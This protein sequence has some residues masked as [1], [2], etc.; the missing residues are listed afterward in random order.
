[1]TPLG[2][3]PAYYQ[4]PA[5]SPDGTRLVYTLSQASSSQSL[6]IYDFE[7]G[8]SNRLTS[9]TDSWPVWSPDGRFVVF[10]ARGGIYW[11]RADGAGKPRRLVESKAIQLPTSLA[12]GGKRMAYS[13][14]LPGAEGEIRTVA[15]ESSSDELRLAGW[16]TRT[17]QAADTRCSSGHFRTMALRHRS[18][19]LEECYPCGPGMDASCFIARSISALW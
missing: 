16:H 3:P 19:M 8:S 18:P 7:R 12:A 11:T 4:Y 5:L 6:W 9:D 17:Q 2:I 10:Q 1:M 14:M 13:Q 15:V